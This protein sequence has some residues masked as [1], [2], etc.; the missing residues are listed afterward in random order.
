MMQREHL[1]PLTPVTTSDSGSAVRPH[2]IP[3]GCEGSRR[4]PTRDDQ[5]WPQALHVSR[6]NRAIL[7]GG[8][9][10]VCTAMKSEAIRGHPPATQ[11]V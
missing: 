3:L 11:K 6:S 9:C 1:I 7:Q 10:S 4:R 2:R 8:D 5:S